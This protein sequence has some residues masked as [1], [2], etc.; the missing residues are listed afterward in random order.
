[1][2]ARV[3]GSM[4]MSL[5]KREISLA[6]AE[7]Q[8]CVKDLRYVLTVFGRERGIDHPH[9]RIRPLFSHN[10]RAV[11]KDV[12]HAIP[13]ACPCWTPCRGRLGLRLGCSLRS[14]I[15]SVIQRQVGAP[16]IGYRAEE[17]GQA[18]TRPIDSPAKTPNSA[19]DEP[20][21]LQPEPTLSIDKGRAIET[22][23]G[24]GLKAGD[25]DVPVA[26]VAY[27]CDRNGV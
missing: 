13:D 15:Q 17:E 26:A 5:R 14:R 4:L 20:G 7:G 19:M 16:G 18:F 6:V 21:Q 11:V 2:D 8:L 3:D 1:M 25:A 24:P 10:V 22:H 27:P 23:L 12:P 9:Q